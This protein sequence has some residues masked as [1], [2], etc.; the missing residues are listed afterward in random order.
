[1]F[2][3]KKHKFIVSS[4]SQGCILRSSLICLEMFP[5]WRNPQHCNC[6][7]VFPELADCNLGL[8]FWRVFDIF[9]LSGASWPRVQPLL[10]WM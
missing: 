4:A 9:F 5:S 2:C 8:N 10:Q 3:P 7:P 1:M 6:S